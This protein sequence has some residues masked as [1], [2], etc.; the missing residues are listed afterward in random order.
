MLAEAHTRTDDIH[1][2]SPAIC[3]AY[4]PFFFS[5]AVASVALYLRAAALPLGV[6]SNEKPVD[7][8]R[9]DYQSLWQYYVGHYECAKT[10]Q[11]FQLRQTLPIFECERERAQYIPLA[12]GVR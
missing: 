9:G 4:D 5:R 2:F 8:L 7:G 11:R 1:S 10:R 12:N 6:A 3:R